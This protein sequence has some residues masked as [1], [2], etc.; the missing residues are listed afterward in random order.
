M[1]AIITPG[2]GRLTGN[3][4]LHL[5]V[6][7][8]LLHTGAGRPAASPG[9]GNRVV[10]G[11]EQKDAYQARP[12]APRAAHRRKP[13][14]PDGTP[15]PGVSPESVPHEFTLQ[16]AALAPP[17]PCRP[18]MSIAV[19]AGNLA[20][21]PLSGCAINLRFEHPVFHPILCSFKGLFACATSRA[22]INVSP[23]PCYERF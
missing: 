9:A 1:A 7:N 16:P 20:F 6:G 5:P 11:I 22:T 3:I 12:R 18:G 13:D 2:A 17:A 19:I 15:A 8:H 4:A 10:V 23:D 14:S 21:S